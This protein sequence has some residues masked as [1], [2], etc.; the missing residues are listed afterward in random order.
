MITFK[1]ST[2]ELFADDACVGS[3]YSGAPGYVNDPAS[4][5]LPDKGPIPPGLWSIG[6]PV[7]ILHSLGSFCLPLT[8]MAGTDALGRSGF[9]I[10]GDNSSRPPRSSSEGCIVTDRATREFIAGAVVLEVIS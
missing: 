1:I 3:G 2:G 10:H 9:F 6:A 8:P 7:D 4:V 5:S